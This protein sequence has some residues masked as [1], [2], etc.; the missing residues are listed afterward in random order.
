VIRACLVVTVTFACYALAPL[1][2][3]PEG[4][5]VLELLLWLLIFLAVIGWQI[6]AVMGSSFPGLRAIEAVAVSLPVFVLLF[7]ATYFVTGQLAPSN[8]SEPLNRIDS[9]YFTVTVFATVGFGDITPKTDA[10]RLLVTFQMIADLVLIGF[11]A[12]I[13]FGVVEHRRQELGRGSSS[14]DN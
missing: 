2:R 8:F 5:V 6:H 10:A 14:A 12:K 13:L 7:S 3:R 1:N 4:A 11:I 9:L